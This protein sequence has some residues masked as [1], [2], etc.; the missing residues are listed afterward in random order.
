M[1]MT[2]ENAVSRLRAAAT[3]AQRQAALKARRKAAGLVPVTNL[4]CHPDDAQPIKDYAAKLARKR[5]RMGEKF[6][7]PRSENGPQMGS[8]S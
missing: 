5:V 4:W 6:P 8:L 7:T 1:S 3:T 2:P